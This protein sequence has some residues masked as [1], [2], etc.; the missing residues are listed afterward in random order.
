M[1]R[2]FIALLI[3]VS[4]SS[5]FAAEPVEQIFD[6]KLANWIGV[7]DYWSF[8]E[9]VFTAAAPNGIKPTGGSPVGNRYTFLVSKKSYGDFELSFRMHQETATTGGVIIRGV[10]IARPRFNVAGPMAM[11]GPLVEWRGTAIGNFVEFGYGYLKSV[12]PPPEL[13][14]L[15]RRGFVHYQ[16]TAIGKRITVR[17]NGVTTI[18]ENFPTIAA[19][20]PIAWYL[21]STLAQQAFLLH[22]IRLRDLTKGAKAPPAPKINEPAQPAP[23]RFSSDM[24][25]LLS[26]ASASY[27]LGDCAVNEGDISSAGRLLQSTDPSVRD[28]AQL[29]LDTYAFQQLRLAQ[30]RDAL[31]EL[32]VRARIGGIDALAKRAARNEK[33]SGVGRMIEDV[34]GDK[35]QDAMNLKFLYNCIALESA[36]RMHARLRTAAEAKSPADTGIK[37]PVKVFCDASPETLGSVSITNQ[38]GRT[39]RNVLVIGRVVVDAEKARESGERE[40]ALGQFLL[41]A[42]GVSEKMKEASIQAGKLR[43]RAAQTNPGNVAFIPEIAPGATVRVFVSHW[44]SMIGAKS[45]DVSLFSDEFTVIDRK[46]ANYF[47]LQMAVK[48]ARYYR[49]PPKRKKD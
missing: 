18:D 3:L 6:E 32:E 45:V 11:G 39:M 48:Y 46:P 40:T 36:A 7:K 27:W 41:P 33:E 23:K 35:A 21:E 44:I 13:I 24:T 16:I 49:P 14:T 4:A 19:R 8:N 37:E 22:D 25:T 29:T 43:A 38:S 42:I 2:T 34:L 47:E 15:E 26:A 5:C 31:K 17:V 9:G 10:P 12:V 20:G 1:H 30:S 28:L